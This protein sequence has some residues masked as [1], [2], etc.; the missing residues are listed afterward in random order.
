MRHKRTQE[1]RKKFKQARSKRKLSAKA[2]N[3][4]SRFKTQAINEDQ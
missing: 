4:I 3:L 2:E 1:N